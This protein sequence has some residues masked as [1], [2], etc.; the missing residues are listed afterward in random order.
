MACSWPIACTSGVCATGSSWSGA[1]SAVRAL[2]HGIIS[3][4]AFGP[5]PGLATRHI[6]TR[7]II[8]AI[9]TPSSVWTPSA[10]QIRPAAV[11]LL[12]L[13]TSSTF[14]APGASAMSSEARHLGASSRSR[15]L[16]EH[17]ARSLPLSLHS[18]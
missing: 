15:S 11:A 9:V 1:R 7:L 2:Q 8:R 10:C 14:D 17:A 12:D 4:A 5:P 3:A 13:L 18:I 6:A 16:S